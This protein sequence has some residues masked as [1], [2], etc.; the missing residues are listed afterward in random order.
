MV[1]FNTTE[2]VVAYGAG[3]V[4]VKTVEYARELGFE[5]AVVTAPRQADSSI[6]NQSQVDLLDSQDIET[7]VTEDVNHDKQVDDLI[8]RQTLGLSFG[9]AWIFDESFI[10]AHNNALVNFHGSRL[11]KDR[12]GGGFS[13]R[14]LR[15]DPLGYS[16]AHLITPGI[17]TG[18]ILLTDEYRFPESCTKPVE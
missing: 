2:R 15:D 4:L 11:P 5:V 7:V 12:G 3:E 6:R 17:D 9:A 16:Q 18:D 13:W 14:I 10:T 8:G 1:S